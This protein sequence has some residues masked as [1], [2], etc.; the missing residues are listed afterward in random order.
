MLYSAGFSYAMYTDRLV[1]QHAAGIISWPRVGN[2][3]RIYL[4]SRYISMYPCHGHGY[5]YED[6]EGDGYGY[7]FGYGLIITITIDKSQ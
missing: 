6:G 3:G 5:G 4:G 7:E 1:T 2:S